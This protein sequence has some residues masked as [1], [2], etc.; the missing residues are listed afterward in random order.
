MLR[1]ARHRLPAEIDLRAVIVGDGRSARG[2][3]ATWTG[4]GWPA[5]SSC[6]AGCRAAGSGGCSSGPTC[7]WRPLRWSRSASR[8]WRPGAADCR[9]WP[10]RAP[11][12]GRSSSRG[13]TAAGR[14]DGDMVRGLVRLAGDP[15][16]RER[17]A[18]HSRHGPGRPGLA[19][20]APPH[21]GRV[22]RRA[23]RSSGPPRPPC[24]VR[25]ASL[26]PERRPV[27][28][29]R[30]A[31]LGELIVVLVLVKVYDQ[32]R[33][34][35]AARARPALHNAHGVLA[36]ER[37]LHLDVELSANHW[38]GRSPHAL[39]GRELVVS[40]GPPHRDA[41]RA[42]LVLPAPARRVPRR[43][44]RAGA[45]QRGRA[46]RVLRLPGDAAAAAARRRL[47]RLG[48][49]RRLRLVP[50]RPGARRPVRGDALAA[51]GLG[52]V[53]GVGGDAAAVPVPAAGAAGCST[54]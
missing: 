49:R 38:T 20:R 19:G 41:G 18:M 43:P 12:S 8:R 26:A 9:S 45:D 1:Q 13:R 34:L 4:T 52:G 3:S 37:W 51:P 42:R 54:R 17:M 36:V 7:S 15:A 5:G 2:W 48:G 50:H 16:E 46:G 31:L 39:A 6:P 25:P 35:E 21:R 22:R 23:T 40:A 30:P 27:R 33:A 10:A 24:S 32:V 44:Q 47:R 53:D 11:G 14:Q 29:R 28:V